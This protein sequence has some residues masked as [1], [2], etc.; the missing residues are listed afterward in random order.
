[1]IVHDMSVSE[2]CSGRQ[3]QPLKCPRTGPI[4]ACQKSPV[5]PVYGMGEITGGEAN[6]SRP[7]RA[8]LQMRTIRRLKKLCSGRDLERLET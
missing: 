4:S 6:R 1:M 7:F 3:S 5:L 2:L 8:D